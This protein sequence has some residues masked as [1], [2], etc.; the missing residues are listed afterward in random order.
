MQIKLDRFSIIL[1]VIMIDLFGKTIAEG[2]HSKNAW[3][4]VL[5]GCVKNY[6]CY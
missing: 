5:Y 4:V 1:C 2:Y 6:I 3:D